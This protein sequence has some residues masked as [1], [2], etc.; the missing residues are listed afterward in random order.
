MALRCVCVPEEDVTSRESLAK[1]LPDGKKERRKCSTWN[2]LCSRSASAVYCG[3]SNHK[4]VTSAVKVNELRV[5]MEIFQNV[6]G[7][8]GF[9]ATSHPQV[10]GSAHFTPANN[11]ALPLICQ[12]IVHKQTSFVLISAMVGTLVISITINKL[13]MCLLNFGQQGGTTKNTE[14][15]PR[16]YYFFNSK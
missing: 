12:N 8:A 5:N 14:K 9:A 2:D 4:R 6:G 3:N 7:S 15:K 13:R 1:S 11:M 16:P 10:E